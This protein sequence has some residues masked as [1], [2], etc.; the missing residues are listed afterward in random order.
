MSSI[1]KIVFLNINSNYSEENESSDKNSNNEDNSLESPMKIL[2]DFFNNHLVLDFEKTT[3]EPSEI[4]YSFVYKIET[5]VTV[6]C[7]F[8]VL[9]DLSKIHNKALGSDSYIV[10]CN[11]NKEESEE[12]LCK[13][14]K[15][16]K[17]YCST[18][19]TT[20][21]VGV[22]EKSIIPVLTNEYIRALLDEEEISYNYYEMSCGDKEESNSKIEC[23]KFGNINI[24]LEK[25]FLNIYKWKKSGSPYVEVKNS[26]NDYENDKSCNIY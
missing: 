24:I 20:N 21:F 16:I 23:K 9:N 3:E 2:D 13:I 1:L 15:Y 19:V 17:E 7:Q 26:K 14:S 22:Y 6:T 18:S 5:D 11:L 10:F 12:K 4:C 25:I 8:Y